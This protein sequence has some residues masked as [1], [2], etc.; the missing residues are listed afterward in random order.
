MTPE[1]KV[2]AK[3]TAL[4]KQR[5]VYFFSPMTHGYGASG[6]PDI[7]GCYKGRFIAVECKAG[8]NKPT[9]LQCR[10]I[11]NIRATQGLALVVNETNID[12]VTYVLDLIDGEP[13]RG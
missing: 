10:T 6:A 12:D 11:D 9:V 7:I 5:G 13:T 1:G 2:K 3:V 4:L 8:K